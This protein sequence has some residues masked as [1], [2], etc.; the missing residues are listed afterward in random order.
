PPWATG[1][2]GVLPLRAALILQD[3]VLRYFSLSEVTSTSAAYSTGVPTPEPDTSRRTFIRG[4]RTTKHR[5][6]TTTLDS[7][8][9]RWWAMGGAARLP[10]RA[11]IP[12]TPLARRAWSP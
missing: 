3:P 6:E 1:V 12:S 2:R 8:I 10:R 7:R 9:T 5:I 4:S 11:A